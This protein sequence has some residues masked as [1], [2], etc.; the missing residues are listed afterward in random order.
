MSDSVRAQP[1][2]ALVRRIR[3]ILGRF[4]PHKEDIEIWLNFPHPDLGGRTPQSV[5]DEGQSGAVLAMLEAAF[6]AFR[7]EKE[8]PGQPGLFI[9]FNDEPSRYYRSAFPFSPFCFSAI[10]SL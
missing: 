10:I 4:F 6:W 2:E 9:L 3:E 5:I 8:R 7:P 1:D